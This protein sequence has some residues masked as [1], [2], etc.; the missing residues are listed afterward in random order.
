MKPDSGS[1]PTLYLAA[2]AARGREPNV[3]PESKPLTTRL[4]LPAAIKLER[5]GYSYSST[6][7]SRPAADWTAWRPLQ[8]ALAAATEGR[9]WASMQG[10]KGRICPIGISGN[11]LGARR[12]RCGCGPHG[13][14]PRL[15]QV[16][17]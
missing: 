2:M 7:D 16:R 9:C 13:S 4:E 17:S 14:R 12:D 6:V 15:G 8:Q 10:A 11:R 1:S 3:V 5:G